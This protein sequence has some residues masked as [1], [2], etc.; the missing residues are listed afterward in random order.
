MV[1]VRLASFIPSTNLTRAA[2]AG[3]I[4]TRIGTTVAKIT[5]TT[6][7]VTDGSLLSKQY[8]RQIRGM[9]LGTL[10]TSGTVYCTALEYNTYTCEVA[11]WASNPFWFMLAIYTIEY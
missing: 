3:V 10:G 2:L 5:A 4:N 9:V 11:Q 7:Y 8:T 1:L 6:V